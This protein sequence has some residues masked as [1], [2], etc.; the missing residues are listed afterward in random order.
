MTKK[1]AREADG[2]SGQDPTVDKMDVEDD[3]EDSSDD[4]GKD[5]S[6]SYSRS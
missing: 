1:R 5:T 3:E 2:Q 6:L 4:V